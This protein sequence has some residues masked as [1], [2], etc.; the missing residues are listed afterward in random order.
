[1]SCNPS[2]AACRSCTSCSI[3]NKKK[4]VQSLDRFVHVDRFLSC[5]FRRKAL[6]SLSALCLFHLSC[7]SFRS[8]FYGGW[9]VASFLFSEKSLAMSHRLWGIFE[10][11]FCKSLQYGFVF[12]GSFEPLWPIVPI[13]WFLFGN[14]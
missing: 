10:G 1:M 2:E 14:P 13:G 8:W 9:C 4:A 6:M 5:A 11:Q 3:C 7:H 12:Y